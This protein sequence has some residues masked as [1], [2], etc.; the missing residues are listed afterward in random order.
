MTHYNVHFKSAIPELGAVG[1]L[2][3]ERFQERL[4]TDV[5]RINATV[6]V[7]D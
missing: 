2:K 3:H 5:E 1:S 7:C 4:K 6:R